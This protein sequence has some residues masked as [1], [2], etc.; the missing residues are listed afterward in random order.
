[1]DAFAF[2]LIFSSLLLAKARAYVE[3]KIRIDPAQC[4]ICTNAGDG[5]YGHL[6]FCGQRF[7]AHVLAY[8]AFVGSLKRHHVVDHQYCN[9]PPCCNPQH[10]QATTQSGNMK[11]CFAEG[12]GRGQFTKAPEGL[13]RVAGVYGDGDGF[14]DGLDAGWKCTKCG[15]MSGD[16]WSQCDDCCPIPFSPHYQKAV[17]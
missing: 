15:C 4:W 7:K 16:N 6:Y 10:L 1:M 9:H 8:L 11:R 2:H 13:I 5:R 12:R 17:L 3:S 14:D